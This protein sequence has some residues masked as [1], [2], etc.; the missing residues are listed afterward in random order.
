MGK[1]RRTHYSHDALTRIER[2][3]AFDDVLIEAIRRD[4]REC[5]LPEEDVPVSS[6]THDEIYNGRRRVP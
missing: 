5:G 6:L 1:Q 2:S 4:R 3:R